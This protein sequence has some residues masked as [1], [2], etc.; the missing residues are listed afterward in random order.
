MNFFVKRHTRGG[1]VLFEDSRLLSSFVFK[2]QRRQRLENWRRGM[3]AETHLL[4]QHLILP[5][6]VHEEPESTPITGLPGAMRY[7]LQGLK[8]VA[9]QAADAGIA[10]LAL[11][12]V[13]PALRKSPEAHEALNPEG[14]LCRALQLVKNESRGLGLIADVAL[15][16][17]TDHGHDGLL[18]NNGIANDA[19]VEVLS[20]QAVLYAQ[21]GASAVAP[22]DMLDGRVL[23]IR[24]ALERAGYGETLLISYA[25][26]FAS[27]LYAPFRGAVGAS[28]LG[29]NLTDKK[30]YQLPIGNAKEALAE[31]QT[32]IQEGADALIIKPGLA[33][34]DIVQRLSVHTSVPLLSYIVSG[35]AV[36]LH[37]AVATNSLEFLPVLLEQLLCCRRAGASGIITYDALTAAK[38][39]A[40][41]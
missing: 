16:P 7:S 35:E 1:T 4:P 29:G 25:A 33:Y 38:A 2:R 18:N 19:T 3:F 28:P 31:A 34:L 11:F 23:A 15:D 6:F 37:A 20:R 39:L 8:D 17:Y 26:K 21:A 10:A 24:H 41:L 30:S 32:D 40:K 9:R 13:I 14:L 36:M 5:V 12:P 27:H 22:S